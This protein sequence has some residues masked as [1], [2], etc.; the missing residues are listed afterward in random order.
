VFDAI[1]ESAAR[2]CDARFTALY[3]YD[4]DLVHV[5]AHHNLTPE[6]LAVLQRLYPMRPTHEQASGR[7]IMGAAVVHLP[8]VLADPGY[9]HEVAIAGGWQASSPCQ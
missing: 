4:G 7:A 6:V 9:R 2:L 5:A 3:R 8:D 1:V